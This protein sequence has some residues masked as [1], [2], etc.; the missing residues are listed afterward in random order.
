MA[1]TLIIAGIPYEIPDAGDEPG[2]G[3]Q[4]SDWMEA[5]T[6]T[7][8]DLV[9]P[10][11]IQETSFSVANN[12]TVFVDVTGL[13]FN[14]GSVRSSVVQYS[15]YRISDANPEGNAETGNMYIVYDN[16]SATP[17]SLSIG[18]V[19]GNANI[20]FQITNGGQIQYRTNDIGSLNYVGTMR[21]SAKSQQQ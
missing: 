3:D 17:W 18:N 8:N 15:V 2:W 13:L 12:Q 6:A 19:V 7:L 5:V 16:N 1:R 21:F 11:D 14:G 9:G 10:D 4:T 20:Y